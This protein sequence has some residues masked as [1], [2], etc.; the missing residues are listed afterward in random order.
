MCG[1]LCVIFATLE[2]L[3]LV[4]VPIAVA[5]PRCSEVSDCPLGTVCVDNSEAHGASWLLM[6]LDCNTVWNN[7]IFLLPYAGLPKMPPDGSG[8]RL[9]IDTIAA[10]AAAKPEDEAWESF[11]FDRW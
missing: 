4:A 2:T 9:S 6:C 10:A 11:A 8:W 5:A 1:C 7:I 3:I